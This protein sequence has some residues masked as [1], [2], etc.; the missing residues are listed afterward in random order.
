MHKRTLLDHMALFFCRLG[1]AGLSPYAPGTCGSALAAIVAPW[2]FMPLYLPLRFL[3]LLLIF[4]VGSLAA[5]RAEEILNT[6][7]PGQVVVDELLGVWMVLLPFA[8]APWWLLFL[9]F[10]VFRF[11]D[12]LKPW[13]VK[14]SERWLPGGY[15]VMIDDAVAALQALLVLWLAG[16]LGVVPLAALYL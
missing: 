4:F 16:L 1:F 12:I 11:F 6:Q 14:A 7:D 10:A 8:V 2:L 3:L 9:A 13:P 5:T 15:G